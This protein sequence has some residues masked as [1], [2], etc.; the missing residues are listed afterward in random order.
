MT[1]T[2]DSPVD[3]ARHSDADGPG[4]RS[5]R[6]DGPRPRIP[7]CPLARTAQTIGPWW[8]LEILHEILDGNTDVDTV[9][10]NLDMPPDLLRQRLDT[11]V[12]KGLLEPASGAARYRATRRGRALR[13]LILVMA[14][15]GNHELAPEERGLVIVD[16]RT[17]VEVEPVVVDRRS[18]EPIDTPHHVFARGPKASEQLRAR[19]PEIPK[20][21]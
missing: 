21:T 11:L 15:W 14:A 6:S 13:P 20:R 10:R 12:A 5:V 3:K 1:T 17:G 7:D 19:Y 18:G 16:A 9:S 8:T 2:E 4:E